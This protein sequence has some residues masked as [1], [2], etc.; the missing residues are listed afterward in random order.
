MSAAKGTEKLLR[1]IRTATGETY[2]AL[3]DSIVAGV[4]E[5]ERQLAEVT[6]NFER[7]C[8]DGDRLAEALGV[9]RTEGGSLQVVRMLGV[10]AALKTER[11]NAEGMAGCMDM[12]RRDL[13][14]A[15]VI[16]ASGPPMFMTEAVMRIVAE[17]D[18]AIREV[19]TLKMAL[20]D[21][22][23]GI[24][25]ELR[26][27]EIEALR[28]GAE[29]LKAFA[30]ACLKDWPHN[31]GL[32]GFDLQ[33]I[34]IAHGLLV[35]EQRTTFCGDECNCAEYQGKDCGEFTC[36]HRADWLKPSAI[37]AARGAKHNVM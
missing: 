21:A 35:G 22:D 11:D 14:A 33:D 26:Q 32:D 19:G 23:H 13:I 16:P 8:S 27:R 30:N 5:L 28:V 15:G 20:A 1:D 9:P 12:L 25:A 7:E 4:E 2:F 6:A 3:R 31:M 36:Y 29:R 37:D 18:E 17:R 24:T 34:C 10:I